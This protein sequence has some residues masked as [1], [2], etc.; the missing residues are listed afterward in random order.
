LPPKNA[1]RKRRGLKVPTT[2]LPA[3]L[4]QACPH[5]LSVVQRLAAVKDWHGY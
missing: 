3:I 4:L 5:P 1:A 2:L